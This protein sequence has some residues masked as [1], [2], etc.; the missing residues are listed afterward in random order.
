MGNDLFGK[1]TGATGL[2][3]DLVCDEL[4]RLLTQEGIKPEEMTLEDLRK[5]LANYV[6]DV[7]LAAK[8][9]CAENF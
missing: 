7:L 9:A 1:V 2:P 4:E 3:T 6:Q 5:V 8:E